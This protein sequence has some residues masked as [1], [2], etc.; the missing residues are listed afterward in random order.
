MIVFIATKNLISYG[1]CFIG[2]VL[3]VANDKLDV[4]GGGYGGEWWRSW[5]KGSWENGEERKKKMKR[6]ERRKENGGDEHKKMMKVERLGE[7]F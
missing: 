5:E 1:H 6:K 4:R 3:E 7:N 2:H